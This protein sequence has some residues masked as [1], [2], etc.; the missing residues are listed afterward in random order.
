[1]TMAELQEH[2]TCIGYEL[3]TGCGDGASMTG[4]HVHGLRD[5]L[6]ALLDHLYIERAY[7]LGFSFGSMIALAALAGQPRRFGRALLVGGFARRSLAWTEVLLAHWVRY[8]PGHIRDLPGFA[9]L[10]RRDSVDQFA[11]RPPGELEHFVAG[12]CAPLLR[13]F[14]ARALLMH[15]TDLRPMLSQ[16]SQPVLLVHGDCDPLVS[17]AH[18]DELKQALPNAALAT[19]KN[20]GHYPQLTHPDVFNEVVR[21]FLIPAAC[22]AE[23]GVLP[24]A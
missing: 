17:R 8:C 18:E 14:A 23:N 11:A 9:A 13:T 20:C 22:L 2:V 4:Y 19:I 21:Q 24:T 16:I 6:Y 1:M 3:P 7:L 5:D 15:H 12:E 10:V